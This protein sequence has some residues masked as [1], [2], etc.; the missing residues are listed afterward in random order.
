MKKLLA[1]TSV[2]I[3]CMGN[4]YPVKASVSEGANE[5]CY[6]AR[7]ANALGVALAPGTKVALMTA[8]KNNIS[9]ATYKLVWEDTKK[10]CPGIF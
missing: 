7:K 6:S 4:D 1:I 2:L 9:D 8:K 5:V 3:C 10:I